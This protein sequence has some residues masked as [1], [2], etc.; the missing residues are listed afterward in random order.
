MDQL[1]DKE[2][3]EE[4]KALLVRYKQGQDILDK[5][6]ALLNT[7]REKLPKKFSEKEDFEDF[8]ILA[9]QLK[10]RAITLQRSSTS[11][12]GTI[13]I[14]YDYIYA[15]LLLYS[16]E[17]FLKD[18]F[19]KVTD[20]LRDQYVNSKKDL[21]ALLKIRV[22]IRAVEGSAAQLVRAFESDEVNCRK[23]LDLKNKLKGL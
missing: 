19:D 16:A 8:L 20:K 13:D 21:K 2:V 15:Q 18:K 14:D 5:E 12:S 4:I 1:T 9:S 6:L 7:Q 3:T 17:D 23:F 11:M 10:H 22:K